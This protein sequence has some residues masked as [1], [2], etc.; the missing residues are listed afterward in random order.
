MH[1]LSFFS[2][3]SL[4]T[5]A[6]AFAAEPAMLTCPELTGLQKAAGLVTWMNIMW[7]FAIVL[8]IVCLGVLFLE[9]IPLFAEIPAEAYEIALY[10]GSVGLMGWGYFLAPDIG[11]YV[12]FTGCLM[13]GASIMFTG[14]I[15]KLT[16]DLVR[17]FGILFVVW[18]GIALVYGSPLI[19]FI[20][21]MALMGMLGFS[22]VVTPLSYC[23]G[24]RDDD[25]VG[26]ATSA[27]FL[28]LGL[29]LGIRILGSN[30][31]N[32]EN[33]MVFE[34][35]ALWMG[36]FVGYLGLLIASSRWYKTHFPYVLMQAVTIAAGLGAIFVGSLRDIPELLGIGG[37]FFALYMIEKPFEIPAKSTLGY[38]TIGLL[39]SAGVYG[40]VVWAKTHIDIVE[41]YL[42]F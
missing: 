18:S 30:A 33:I 22:V 31:P 32:L 3:V 7:V 13:L 9:L 14:H 15:H 39:V 1:T 8:G 37:T 38:A 6:A 20:A 17:F 34:S 2:V 36:S 26:N 12:G 29:F 10:A 28:I 27:A 5:F 42:L 16:Q 19:G 11:P 4:C 35:G 41:P 24:F 25:A 23:I 40:G 21:V